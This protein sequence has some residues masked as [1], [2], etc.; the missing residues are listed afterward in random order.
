MP[1]V[2][3]VF[4]RVRAYAR[5]MRGRMV[6]RS[7]PLKSRRYQMPPEKTTRPV[8]FSAIGAVI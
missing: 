1:I 2:K 8:I 4:Q 5:E 7:L 6:P 3:S